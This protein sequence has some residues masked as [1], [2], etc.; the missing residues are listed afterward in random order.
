[1]PNKRLY[2]VVV[3]GS[4]NLTRISVAYPMSTNLMSAFAKVVAGKAPGR[5]YYIAEVDHATWGSRQKE[6]VYTWH[7]GEGFKHSDGWWVNG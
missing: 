1:M 4:R 5:S 7:V 2:A 6:I 3:L